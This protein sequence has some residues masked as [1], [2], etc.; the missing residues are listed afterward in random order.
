MTEKEITLLVEA[1]I[2]YIHAEYLG[3][4]DS[5]AI[6]NITYISN[7]CEK[8]QDGWN[9]DN[10]NIS[11]HAY[12]EVL[13]PNKLDEQLVEDMAYKHLNVIEDWWNND[14]GY[15]CLVIEVPSLKFK[16]LNVVEYR[17][18][19]SYNHEGN[20]ETKEL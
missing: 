14:G 16:N 13:R 17:E 8:M 1:G 4:G 15:G 11:A 12:E 5:G 6:E 10:L 19:E 20:F 3:G 7:S 2:G 9:E 18:T